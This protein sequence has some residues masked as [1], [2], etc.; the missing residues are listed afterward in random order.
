[1][2]DYIKITDDKD[3]T[4]DDKTNKYTIVQDL[5]IIKESVKF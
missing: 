5:F 1:M 3:V 2:T 4:I